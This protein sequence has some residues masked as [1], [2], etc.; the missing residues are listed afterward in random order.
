[1]SEHGALPSRA[2]IVATAHETISGGSLSFAAASRLFDRTMRQRAWLLYAWCRR[3]DDLADAQL[4]GHKGHSEE[5]AAARLALIRE[6]TEAVLSGKR[7]G[8]PG[9]DALGVLNA[10]LPLPRH[11]IDDVIAGFALDVEDW[12]PRTE[13]DLLRY[14]YHVAGAVGCLMALVMGVD[15]KD[16]ATLDRACDL[17]ISFQLSNIARDVEADD[18]VGRC[19]L[20]M[21]WLAEMDVSPGQHVKP[22]YR[23]RLVVLVRR[24]TDLAAA[25]EASGRAG[26][27]KLPF[28]AAW[29]VL[30][31]AGIYGAIGRKVA[32]AGE[33]AWDH[34]IRTR[35]FEKIGWIVRAFGQ[36]SARARLYGTVSRDAGL[37]DR[38]RE[39]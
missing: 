38:P 24:L 3:C 37:W 12:R 23:G 18:R 20:P 25:Y 8:D 17:G 39:G 34:R 33:H 30:A 13:A 26:T 1:M 27:P 2:A 7:I 16:E 14:C 19:Y 4:L 32:A 36:A 5:D 21:E 10:E 31:A 22:H 6:G 11:L 9:F 29:A 28:R 15:A 35:N